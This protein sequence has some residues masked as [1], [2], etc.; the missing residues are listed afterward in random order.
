MIPL[1]PKEISRMW[2]ILK[3]YQFR[4]AHGAFPGHDIVSDEV[5]K[6]VLESMKIQVRKEEY[7]DHALLREEL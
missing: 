1:G 6:R 7:V 5:K 2:G 3:Q 4:S